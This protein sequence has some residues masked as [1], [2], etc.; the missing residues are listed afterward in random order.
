MKNVRKYFSVLFIICILITLTGCNKMS[1]KE[2][3]MKEYAVDFYNNYLKGYE[4]TEPK[5]VTIADLKKAVEV[6]G[7]DYDLKKLEKCTDESYAEL[8]IDSNTKE[9][10]DV[11]FYLE[12]E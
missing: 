12:C 9:V 5:T 6:V 1:A 11:N 7:K 4:S 2:K 8:I 3:V 10:T